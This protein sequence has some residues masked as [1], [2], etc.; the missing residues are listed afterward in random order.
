[1]ALH[2]L[3]LQSRNGTFGLQG[4][5]EQSSP[6]KTF[7]NI[8]TL[9]KSFCMKFCKFVGIQTLWQVSHCLVY[10]K[11]MRHAVDSRMRHAVD[12]TLDLF[13]SAQLPPFVTR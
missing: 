7:W 6:P 1:L 2:G 5:S 11:R 9:V 3:G 4:V 8:L 10:A 12:S 13:N